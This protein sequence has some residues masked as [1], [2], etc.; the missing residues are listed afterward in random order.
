MIGECT[1]QTVA[2][3]CTYDS[4]K[5]GKTS[6]PLIFVR[7][8]FD[9]PDDPGPSHPNFFNETPSRKTLLMTEHHEWNI[10]YVLQMFYFSMECLALTCGTDIKITSCLSW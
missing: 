2:F 9:D 4:E 3:N 7:L 6:P 8:H 5:Y 10:L 1:V